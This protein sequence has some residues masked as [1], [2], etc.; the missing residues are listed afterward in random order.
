MPAIALPTSPGEIAFLAATIA[1]F[2]AFAV[3]LLWVSLTVTLAKAPAERPIE[4]EVTPARQF[5]TA[6]FEPKKAA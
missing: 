3:T 2:V 6:A 5:A 1:G 4:R